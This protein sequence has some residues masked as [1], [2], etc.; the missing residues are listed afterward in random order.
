M[1][2]VSVSAVATVPTSVIESNLS[3]AAG[4]REVAGKAAGK[5]AA[6]DALTRQISKTMGSFPIECPIG[7][8]EYPFFLF[9]P[10]GAREI[11]ESELIETGS[12]S[13][14]PLSNPK[15]HC[16]AKQ[17]FRLYFGC[18][19]DQTNFTQLAISAANASITGQTS[20]MSP[21]DKAIHDAKQVAFYAVPTGRTDD[22]ISFVF[23]PR[24]LHLSVIERL[25]DVRVPYAVVT[26]A[27]GNLHSATNETL[28]ALAE[29]STVPGSN[30]ARIR[31][32]IA[33]NPEVSAFVANVLRSRVTMGT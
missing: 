27:C 25:K 9:R 31:N 26:D 19:V 18:A 21:L 22:P 23:Q 33:Q 2:P 12:M 8:I 16:E 5:A 14:G 13:F 29:H 1:L 17:P 32:F 7:C 28:T 10:V 11:E 30:L 3:I 24:L 15:W 20:M 4:D 6:S